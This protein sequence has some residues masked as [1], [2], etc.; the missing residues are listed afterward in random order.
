MNNF[1][2]LILYLKN[3]RLA[4]YEKILSTALENNYRII[5][6]RDFA[7][8][9]YSGSGFLLILRHDID[10][11]SKA[12]GLMFEIEKRLCVHA[13]YYFR[14]STMDIALMERIES[15]GSEASLHFETIA[16]FIK[17]K[18]ISSKNELKQY[19]YYETC[20]ENLKINLELLRKETSFPFATIASHG[21]RA[22][23]KCRI[24]NNMLTEDLRSYSRL[25]I[26]LEAYNEEFI[27]AIT[28]YISDTPVEING[29]YRYNVHPLNAIAA[30]SPLILFLTH[31]EHW[32]YQGKAK[33]RKIIKSIIK[34]N[35]IVDDK[36][37][38]V[39]D[40]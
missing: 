39:F 5:S 12:T 31:P 20:L 6:L 37:R 33:F 1:Q 29:G 13:S 36:F 23:L 28:S 17:E 40:E 8:K 4:E 14:N 21:E 27:K 16:D 32:H 25:G 3:N 18:G 10:K 7:F 11:R 34:K 22:N 35:I 19:D 38:R 2:T 24:S 9:K 30:K 15:F 26:V